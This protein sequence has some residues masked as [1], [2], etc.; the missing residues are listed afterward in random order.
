MTT[1]TFKTAIA[2]IVLT[3]SSLCYTNS[4][5]AE[6]GSP[7]II[8]LPVYTIN[9]AFNV[10]LTEKFVM[11]QWV[12]EEAQSNDYF[13]IERSFNGKDF[14]SIGIALDGFENGSQKM[15]AFKHSLSMLKN[16]KTAQYRL[17]HVT[18]NGKFSYSSV[19]AVN[20]K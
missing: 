19:I 5:S 17:K 10:S 8:T 16:N 3:L 11:L 14:M 9:Y 15:Y 2:I 12:S 4:V 6:T 7:Y 13:E 20:K 1:A 18:A